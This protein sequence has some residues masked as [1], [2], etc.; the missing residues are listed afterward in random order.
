MGRRGDESE[1]SGWGGDKQGEEQGGR[2]RMQAGVGVTEEQEE[3]EEE[4]AAG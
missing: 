3:E 2:W 4:G 1:A